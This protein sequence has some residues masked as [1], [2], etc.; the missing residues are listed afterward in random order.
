MQLTMART[1]SLRPILAL[2]IVALLT[3]L[4]FLNYLDR[5]IVAAVLPKIQEELHLSDFE[6]GLI[7][8]P[9][10]CAKMAESVGCYGENVSD[11]AEVG[12]VLKRALKVVRDGTPAVVAVRLPQLM[13]E[14]QE[15]A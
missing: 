14:T 2:A 11:P 13:V 3:G 9:P 8:P 1:P 7:D 10:D 6:G 12:P 5:Y 4:N 15:R